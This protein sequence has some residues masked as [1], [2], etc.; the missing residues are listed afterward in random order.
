[1]NRKKRII[2]QIL[3]TWGMLEKIH[4]CSNNGYDEAWITGML[5]CHLPKFVKGFRPETSPPVLAEFYTKTTDDFILSWARHLH[6]QHNIPA[7]VVTG[8]E[9][10]SRVVWEYKYP[11]TS[12]DA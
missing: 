7:W 1:M 8:C 10:L 12:F 6:K 4:E 2:P 3:V 11:R 9:E 5:K